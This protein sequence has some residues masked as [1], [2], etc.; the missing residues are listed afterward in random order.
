MVKIGVLLVG[1]MDKKFVI[2]QLVGRDMLQRFN[3]EYGV[4]KV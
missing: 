3:K 4:G 2:C 1:G